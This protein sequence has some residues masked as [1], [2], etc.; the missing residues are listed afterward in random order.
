[1][2]NYLGKD[3][4]KLGFGLMRLP[5]IDGKTDIEQVKT[6]VD[7]FMERGF[8]YFD[9]AYVYGDGESERAAKAAIVDRYPRES[10]RLAT[11]LPLFD[12]DETLDEIKQ[13]FYTSLERTG[14]GYFDF[15]LIHNVAG[16]RRA[17][18]EKWGIWQWLQEL[19]AE[20]LVRHAG[21]SFHDNAEMLDEILTAHPEAEFVQLQINY[22]D[23]EDGS[24]QSRACYEVA[25]KHGVPVIIMEPVKGGILSSLPMEAEELMKAKKPDASISSWAMR[26]CAGLPGVI[27]VLSGM[28]NIEQMADNL[29]SLGNFEPLSDEE[30][31]IVDKSLEIIA[32]V[33][34]IPCTK[35]KYCVEGCPQKINIPGIFGCANM[36][37]IYRNL[38]KAKREYEMWV[39]GPKG[40]KASECIACGA[41]EGICPQHIAIIDALKK[42]SE[43]FD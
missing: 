7:M 8:T 37:T 18:S 16:N 41:C 10:F 2:E 15:Y 14:A 13:R 23:W 34:T 38:P 28:S 26:W 22:K 24:I 3:I 1:M 25:M 40:A 4:G 42:A 19:K 32:A 31:A 29:E 17:L 6:M 33:P 30:K 39:V 35:C 36:N 21:F 12:K 27:T 9:T 20:G 5:E 11:K 43:L